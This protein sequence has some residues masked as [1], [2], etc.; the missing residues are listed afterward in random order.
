MNSS[1]KPSGCRIGKVRLL[2]QLEFKLNS[3]GFNL[4][5]SRFSAIPVEARRFERHRLAAEL[6]AA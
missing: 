4:E 2:L 6:T 5:S 3:E 1:D